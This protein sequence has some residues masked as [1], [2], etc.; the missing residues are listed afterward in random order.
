MS[1]YSFV[2]KYFGL[3]FAAGMA[4]GFFF[5]GVFM[6]IGDRI[7]LILGAVV[8]LTFLTLDL[9]EA[10]ANL[11]RFHNVAGAVLISK[12]VIPF[13]LYRLTLPLGQD[14]SVGVLLLT[15]TPFAAVSPTLTGIIGG[16]TEFT[17]L[18][19]VIQTLLAP[20]YMP[21]LLLLIAGETIN[22]D[23]LSMMKTLIILI[24]IPFCISLAARSLLRPVILKTGKYYGAITII[25]ITVLLMGLLAGIAAPV[26]EAPEEALKMSASALLL[27]IL[28]MLAGWFGFFFLDRRK[29]LGMAVGNLYMNIGLTAVIA[30]GFF[31]PGVMMLVLMYELPANLYPAILGRVKLFRVDLHKD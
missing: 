7:L 29:R 18:T 24:I 14:F 8:T 4:L 22:L 10:A 5:P 15:L 23:A 21:F 19:Q 13:L 30:A 1:W 9:G 17:L 31:S 12:T 2:Q 27:G 28:L 20:F 11:K 6:P 25:L 3:F 16:D 26:R